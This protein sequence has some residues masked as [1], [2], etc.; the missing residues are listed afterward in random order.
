MSAEFLISVNILELHHETLSGYWECFILSGLAV[1]IWEVELDEPCS[2]RGSLFP[3]PQASVPTVLAQRRPPQGLRCSV[4]PVSRALREH[5]AL[6]P[7]IF[8]AV[9]SLG[10]G[11]SLTWAP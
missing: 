1:K 6:G 11:I 4:W 2:G 7:L 9:L 8:Q 3:T 10:L 5:R